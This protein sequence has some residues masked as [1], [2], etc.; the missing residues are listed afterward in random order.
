MGW[1]ELDYAIA[2]LLLP[3]CL[4]YVLNSYD[5]YVCLQTL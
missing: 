5:C 1:A 4:A 2:M 3:T